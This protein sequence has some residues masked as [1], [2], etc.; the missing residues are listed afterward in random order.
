MLVVDT[1]VWVDF[2]NGHASCEAEYLAGCLA[3]DVPLVLPGIVLT[4][5][6]AGLKT[7]AEARRIASL[8]DA[9]E[10]CPEASGDDYR[11]AA[12]MYRACRHAG[13]AVGS[14]VD[15]I[16]AQACVRNGYRLL[17]KDRDFSRIAART[18]LKLVEIG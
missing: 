7:E 6:L 16:I 11:A 15:C 12:G 13:H 8:L 5:I 4:E 3:D 1:S 2:L 10:A 9:F 14:V 17:S 18:P